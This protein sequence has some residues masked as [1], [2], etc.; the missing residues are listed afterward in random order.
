LKNRGEDMLD[1]PECA[2]VRDSGLNKHMHNWL[3]GRGQ[4]SVRHPGQE[5]V[6]DEISHRMYLDFS[7]LLGLSRQ[8][9]GSGKAAKTDKKLE[10][11]RQEAGDDEK[12]LIRRTRCG[13]V[14]KP[15]SPVFTL[16]S[17]NATTSPVSITAT[18]L[19]NTRSRRDRDR[20][21]MHAR[22]DIRYGDESDELY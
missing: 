5:V 6:R 17:V 11:E 20:A 1:D 18:K 15:I 19:S 12:N 3:G 14:L 4:R 16:C 7:D 22:L 21:E 10:Q 2:R 8:D 9:A 13:F